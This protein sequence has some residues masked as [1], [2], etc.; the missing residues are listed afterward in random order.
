M[1]H[2]KGCIRSKPD[3]RDF[4]LA[5]HTIPTVTPP[6]GWGHGG[7]YTNWCGNG[8]M[9]LLPG[10]QVPPSWAISRGKPAGN[11]VWAAWLNE[12]KEMLVDAGA[13]PAEALKLVGNAE[14]GLQLYTNTGYNL[15]TG[16]GDNGT[17][18]RE[19][20]L[21]GQKTGMTLTDGTVHKTGIFAKINPQNLNE[22][23]FGIKYFE[24]VVLGVTANKPNEQAFNDAYPAGIAVWDA[25]GP[26]EGEDHCIP[27]VGRPDALHKACHRRYRCFGRQDNSCAR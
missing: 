4:L 8:N 24:A 10:E 21:F 20:L 26:E 22:M 23:L 1:G 27:A 19:R 16:E 15:L 11:C 13:T 17:E 25:V 5:S 3:P 12:V 7:T 6:W 14:H 9:P 2:A 18:I